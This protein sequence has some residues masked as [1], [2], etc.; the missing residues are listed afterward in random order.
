MQADIAMNGDIRGYTIR[1]VE[2]GKLDMT[3]VHGAKGA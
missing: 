2:N 3:W 1:L